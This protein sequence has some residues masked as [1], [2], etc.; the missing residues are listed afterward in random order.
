MNCIT[1]LP[2]QDRLRPS[3]NTV[4]SLLAA[5]AAHLLHTVPTDGKTLNSILKLTIRAFEAHTV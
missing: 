4:I 1:K 2:F 5:Q 3:A